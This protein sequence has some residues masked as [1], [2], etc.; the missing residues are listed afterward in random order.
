MFNWWPRARREPTTLPAGLRDAV[1][2]AFPF[3]ALPDRAD[4]DQLARLAADFLEDKAITPVHDLAL[5][6]FARAAIAMQAAL[7]VLH[8]GPQAYDE[9]SEI[10][11]YPGEFLVRREVAD[12]FGLVHD[13]SGARAGETMAG[14]PVVLG[15][16]EVERGAGRS[17][18]P[19]YAP[20]IHEFA[21]KLDLRNGGI[22]DGVPAFDPALHAGI[23]PDDWIGELDAAHEAFCWA[24]DDLEQRFPRDIDPESDAGRAIYERELPLD[25][26]AADSPAEFFAVA[27]EAYFVTPA[28]LR[29]AFPHLAALFDAYF[30]PGCAAS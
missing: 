22:A 14:G 25:A 28:R 30:R 29:D 1:V 7:P 15:W 10:V 3:L 4:A 9:F 24:L 23:D 13:D 18:G 21:H 16:A 27:T 26:Y 19:A 20:V 6:D 2:A 8:L 12:E 5:D 11:V 17:D